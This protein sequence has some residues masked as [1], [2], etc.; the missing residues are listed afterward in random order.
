MRCRYKGLIFCRNNAL[1]HPLNN[2]K[3][4]QGTHCTKMGADSSAEIN[5]NVPKFI[6]PNCL[7]KP[8][9]LGFQ[10]K[11]ASLGV[12]SPCSGRSIA[13][14]LC[15]AVFTLAPK[16][17]PL[18]DAFEIFFHLSWTCT[19]HSCFQSLETTCIFQTFYY[20]YLNIVKK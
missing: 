20:K 16:F 18:L 5:P 2:G 13:Y 6:C 11:K 19:M 1:N 4:K 8:K 14:L 17:L 12:R 7:P 10:W 9:S 3:Y 15:A